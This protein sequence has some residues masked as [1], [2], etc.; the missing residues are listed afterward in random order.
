MTH[1]FLRR[2]KSIN[3]GFRLIPVLAAVA[4]P[5]SALQPVPRFPIRS[6]PLA[7]TR[8]VEAGKPFTVAGEHGAIIH[9]AW[10]LGTVPF[11][12]CILNLAFLR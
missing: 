6:S 8:P 5:A 4:W 12:F 3:A 7:I 1:R 2:G 10:E 11:Q 9:K